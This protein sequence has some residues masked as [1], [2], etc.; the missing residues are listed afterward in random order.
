MLL[1]YSAT[2]K[3]F[4]VGKAGVDLLTDE[5]TESKVTVPAFGTMFIQPDK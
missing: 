2:E 4:D 5:A 1:N 3:K